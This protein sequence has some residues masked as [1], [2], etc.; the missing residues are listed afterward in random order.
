MLD[1]SQ[2]MFHEIE[3]YKTTSLSLESIFVLEELILLLLEEVTLFCPLSLMWSSLVLLLL[4]ED[5]QVRRDGQTNFL[6]PIDTLNQMV[7]SLSRATL[8]YQSTL[9]ALPRTYTPVKI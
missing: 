7:L 9:D 6:A 8:Q 4:D 3:I 1:P 2:F 5:T